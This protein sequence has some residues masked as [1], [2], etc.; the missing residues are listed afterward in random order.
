MSPIARQRSGRLAVGRFGLAL[1]ACAATTFASCGGFIG[2]ERVG[3]GAT[4]EQLGVNALTAGT[5]SPGTALVLRGHALEQRF[6][7]DPLGT[8]AELRRIVLTERRREHALAV[9][10]LSFLAAVDEDSR[11]LYFTAACYAWFALFD[12]ALGPAFTAFDPRFRLSCD[13]YNRSLW[14]SLKDD[15]GDIV[16]VPGAR[17]V[18][19][20]PID[21]AVD[22][23]N[24]AFDLGR[25]PRFVPA[26]EFR[27]I[28]IENRHRSSG[29]GAPLIAVAAHGTPRP[30]NTREALSRPRCAAATL[31]LRLDGGVDALAA[32][33]LSSTLELRQA[34]KSVAVQVGATSVPLEYDITATIA[35]FMQETRLLDFE[36]RMFLAAD[37]GDDYFG[38]FTPFPY[39][40]GRVPVVFVHG[41]NSSLPRWSDLLNDLLADDE[42]RGGIQPWFF[43]YPSSVPIAISSE[44][45]RRAL[46]D[47]RD[48][49]DPTHSDPALDAMMV[50]G[51]SQGGLLA[52]HLVVADGEHR[53]WNSIFTKSIDQ[54]DLDPKDRDF[55]RE[56]FFFEPS[57]WVKRAVYIATPHRGSYQADRWIVQAVNRLLTLPAD[58]LGVASDVILRN[59]D[60]LRAGLSDTTPGSLNGMRTDNPYLLALADLKA[61]PGVVEHCICAIDG[62][63]QPPHGSDGVVRYVSA[64]LEGAASSYLVRDG[65]SCQGNPLVVNEVRRIIREHVSAFRA[66]RTGNR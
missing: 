42:V 50:V 17:L 60:S 24:V 9:A 20:S 2:V 38:L 61:A 11:D 41:T 12:E 48:H 52:R 30:T 16:I 57:P 6:D 13:L 63:D 8:L 1:V 54:L 32:G 18:G 26:S 21:V 59:R 3:P 37:A 43:V 36:L 66:A 10:E 22:L 40:P 29:L 15:Q 65:H 28:G 45:L 44:R 35:Y 5:P 49:C 62:D 33:E 53:L 34:V 46:K 7:S 47:A 14:E 4:R 64:D 27:V 39:T 31:L 56:V 19:G 58:V 51:H 25:L 23:R 55:A